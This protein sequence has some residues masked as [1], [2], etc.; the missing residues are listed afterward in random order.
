MGGEQMTRLNKFAVNVKVLGVVALFGG[1]FSAGAYV[2][3]GCTNPGCVNSDCFYASNGGTY[4]CK[5]FE[6]SHAW[7]DTYDDPDPTSSQKEFYNPTETIWQ[8]KAQ[9][10]HCTRTCANQAPCE[11]TCDSAAQ[12]TT[13]TTVSR[14]KCTVN[15]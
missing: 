1:A 2:R 10:S 3:A 5:R 13:D 6:K 15:P 7:T 9:G 4:P 12:W 11:A 8:K 14:E